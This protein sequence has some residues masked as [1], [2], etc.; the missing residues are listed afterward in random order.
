MAH[1][2]R[3]EI[4]PDLIWNVTVMIEVNAQ[5]AQYNDSLKALD[6]SISVQ[7]HTVCVFV[8]LCEDTPASMHCGLQ[9][10]LDAL[11]KAKWKGCRKSTVCVIFACQAQSRM[12]FH[13]H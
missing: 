8:L 5:H 9:K 6:E 7:K 12:L 10:A 2:T 13:W 4:F 11:A 1:W 3:E